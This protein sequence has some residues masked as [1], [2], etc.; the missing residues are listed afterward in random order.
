ME[1]ED[2]TR[3]SLMTTSYKNI[4]EKGKIA[5]AEPV[6]VEG[7]N[8]MSLSESK[9]NTTSINL[10]AGLNSGIKYIILGGGYTK[11]ESRTWDWTHSYMQDFNGDGLVDIAENGV[12]LFNHIGN[13]GRPYF[14]KSSETTPNPVWTGESVAPSVE[15]QVDTAAERREQEKQNQLIDAVRL[16]QAPFTG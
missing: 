8:R 16:W 4:S 7:A 13:D 5:F 9:T 2:Q 12:V 10:G 3:F 15:F 1:T 14:T 11:D 6:R